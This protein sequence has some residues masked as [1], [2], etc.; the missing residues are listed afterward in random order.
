M[1]FDLQKATWESAKTEGDRE[2][3][4]EQVEKL[5]AKLKREQ[6]THVE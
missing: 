4:T 2:V 6:I 5:E 1:F 3:L